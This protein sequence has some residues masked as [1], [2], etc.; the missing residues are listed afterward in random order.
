[1]LII[2]FDPDDMSPGR[3]ECWH[4][5]RDTLLYG[6]S[7]LWVNREWRVGGKKIIL[8]VYNEV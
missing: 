4:E 1:M 2:R 3:A 6:F 7:G 8:Q 5:R